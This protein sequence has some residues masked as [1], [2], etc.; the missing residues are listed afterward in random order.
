MT[1]SI[2]CNPIIFDDELIDM[3]LEETWEMHRLRSQSQGQEARGKVKVKKVNQNWKNG[4]GLSEPREPRNVS[5]GGGGEIPGHRLK[6]MRAMRSMSAGRMMREEY[7][8]E[9][10]DGP[11]EEPEDDPEDEPEFKLKPKGRWKRT[12]RSMSDG[13]IA[14]SVKKNR[15]DRVTKVNGRGSTNEK[16]GSSIAKYVDKFRQVQKGPPRPKNAPRLGPAQLQSTYD[17]LRSR[18]KKKRNSSAN[19]HTNS[20]VNSDENNRNGRRL[21]G[22]GRREN[23]GS[24]YVSNDDSN[25]EEESWPSD[26]SFDSFF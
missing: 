14:A 24:D 26:G 9:E 10:R 19:E 5:S 2:C 23:D 22:L 17:N 13:N 21:F 16:K 6:Q 4:R 25:D 7:N 20:N 15:N 1:S 12:G 3:E 8:N 11:E 18:G